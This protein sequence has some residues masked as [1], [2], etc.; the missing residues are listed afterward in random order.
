MKLMHQ[1]ML[2]T[3]RCAAWLQEAMW[4]HIADKDTRSRMQAGLAWT[5]VMGVGRTGWLARAVH[6][7]GVLAGEQGGRVVGSQVHWAR[8]MALTVLLTGPSASPSCCRQI[9]SYIKGR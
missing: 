3:L 1:A 5:E 9:V 6:S 8:S 7:C 4:R 2:C